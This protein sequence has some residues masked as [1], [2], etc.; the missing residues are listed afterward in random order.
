MPNYPNSQIL[1][2]S[3]LMK[4]AGDKIVFTT[5]MMFTSDASMPAL[6]STK[7]GQLREPISLILCRVQSPKHSSISTHLLPVLPVIIAEISTTT[8][9]ISFVPFIANGWKTV[10]TTISSKKWV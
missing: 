6:I 5:M 1:T 9:T 10:T 3:P 7:I 8:R 2:L 4:I